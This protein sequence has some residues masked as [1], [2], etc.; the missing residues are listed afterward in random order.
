MKNGPQDCVS[1]WVTISVLT[2]VSHT[3]AKYAN[4]R[5]LQ[6]TRRVG[7]NNL[8]KVVARQHRDS[9]PVPSSRKLNALPHDYRVTHM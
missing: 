7:V 3:T 8:P 6:P 2:V 4:A 5:Q 9:N 1:Q